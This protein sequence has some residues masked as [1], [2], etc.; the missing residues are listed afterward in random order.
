MRALKESFMYSALISFELCL[1]NQVLKS[2][3]SDTMEM[4][5]DIDKIYIPISSSCRHRAR[6]ACAHE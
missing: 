6:H 3:F 1:K 2:I 5:A 4:G